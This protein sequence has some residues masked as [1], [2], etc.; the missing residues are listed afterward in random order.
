MK[1]PDMRLY[2]RSEEIRYDVAF[3]L[4]GT[5]GNGPKSPFDILG[6]INCV[7]CSD[8]MI[9]VVHHS[10]VMDFHSIDAEPFITCEEPKSIEDFNIFQK[11]PAKHEIIVD[12]C[13]VQR[14]LDL[15]TEVQEPKQK[16]LR[17]KYRREKRREERNLRHIEAQIIS[18]QGAA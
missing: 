17:E 15:I 16:E 8:F 10:S 5:V 4:M 14:M 2:A 13:N 18:F 1:H 11:Q 9:Q 7:M 12:P 6:E 3:N